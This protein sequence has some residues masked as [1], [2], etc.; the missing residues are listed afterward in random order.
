[1]HST[2]LL[3]LAVA[4]GLLH[5]ASGILLVDS[6]GALT[7]A[8]ITLG[9]T[10]TAA[11]TAAL[12]VGGALAAAGV[13]AAARAASSRGKRA[14]PTCLP[15]SNPELFITLAASSDKL[16][17]G[18]RLVCE[19]EATPDQ[20]LSHE[21]RLILGLFGRAPAPVAF[22]QLNTPK[23]GFQYA[24]FLGAKAA[25]PAECASTFN[26]CPFDRTVMMRAF[27]NNGTNGL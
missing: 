14:A 8:T 11:T 5:L 22:D 24:A 10:T 16:G 26:Q 3:V 6:T 17:C 1:M 13:L 19:L 23:A 20:A 4:C 25:S 12:A 27:Q 18:M 2:S 21:E 9:T 7:A 15:V